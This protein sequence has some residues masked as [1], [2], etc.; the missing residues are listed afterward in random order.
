MTVLLVIEKINEK[1]NSNNPT[2][3][4]EKEEALTKEQ[5]AEKEAR[6]KEIEEKLKK[7]SLYRRK[8]VVKGSG[9]R[10]GKTSTSDN[11]KTENSKTHTF[12]YTGKRGDTLSGIA[13][14]YGTTVEKLMKANTSIKDPNLIYDGNRLVIPVSGSKLTTGGTGKVTNTPT[15]G[16]SKVDLSGGSAT[17]TSRHTSCGGVYGTSCVS[18]YKLSRYKNIALQNFESKVRGEVSTGIQILSTAGGSSK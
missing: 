2:S 12:T 6:Q 14:K 10:N 5:K 16:T 18:D 4:K 1:I 13:K 9:I 17:G 11:S 7:D 15:G 3:T 8:K